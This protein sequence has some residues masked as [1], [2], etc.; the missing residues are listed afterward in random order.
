MAPCR[1]VHEHSPTAYRPASVARPCD[2][3]GDPAHHV[4]RGRRHRHE[5]ALGVDPGLA[6]RADHVG[7]QRRVDVAHVEADRRGAG[8][9]HLALHRAG[10]LVARGEL[11]DEALAGARRAAAR[12]RRGPPR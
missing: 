11:V 1:P 9:R 5:L 12:P 8:R 6:Q 3:G 4:V 10:D 2:V 7:E